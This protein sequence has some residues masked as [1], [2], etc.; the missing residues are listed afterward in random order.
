MMP[1]AYIQRACNPGRGIDRYSRLLE[2]IM[3]FA[4]KPEVWPN[5]SVDYSWLRS[6][7]YFRLLT[8]EKARF[9]F[10]R[11][12][13]YDGKVSGAFCFYDTGHSYCAAPTHLLTE[14]GR[15][16]DASIYSFNVSKIGSTTSRKQRDRKQFKDP[17]FELLFVDNDIG[18]E[19]P[20]GTLSG[21]YLWNEDGGLFVPEPV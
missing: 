5:N 6:F 21:N 18:D 20:L 13:Q 1:S 19:G 8:G 11:F 14:S 12:T 2:M 10:D 16:D 4:A 17:D 9:V 15:K 3:E 7:Q